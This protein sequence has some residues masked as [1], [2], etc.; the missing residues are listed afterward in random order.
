M[1]EIIIHF[2]NNETLRKVFGRIS[3]FPKCSKMTK[4]KRTLQSALMS[5]HLEFHKGYSMNVVFIWTIDQ[6]FDINFAEIVK[7]AKSKI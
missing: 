2:G 5:H 7:V 4:C 3:L 1:Q 6:L